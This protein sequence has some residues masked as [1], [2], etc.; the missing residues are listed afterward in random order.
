MGP[1][2]KGG[3]FAARGAA[4][5]ADGAPDFFFI[6]RR[7]RFFFEWNS[8]KEEI[9]QQILDHIN[10]SKEKNKVPSLKTK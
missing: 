5:A 6:S 3:R 4:A 9:K 2:S 7:P 10:I 1:V 8:N